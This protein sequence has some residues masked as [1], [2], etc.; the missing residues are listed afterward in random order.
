M[1]TW[2][3]RGKGMGREGRRESKIKRKQENE[4]QA[5]SPFY[6]KSGIPGCCQATVGQS[7]DRM[8]TMS[9]LFYS[10]CC[11]TYTPL[12]FS[13][14]RFGFVFCLETNSHCAT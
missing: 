6:S 11:R 8:L 4:E 2:R 13:L 1:S 3:E 7:L 10:K 5:S 14:I 9:I 12:Y